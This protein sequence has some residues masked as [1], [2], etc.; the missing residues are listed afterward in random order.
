VTAAA[1]VSTLINLVDTN[2]L[3]GRM[4][5]ATRSSLTAAVTAISDPRERALTALYL[6]AVSDFAVHQ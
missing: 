1:S 3:S 4:S 5:P 2:L 6:S